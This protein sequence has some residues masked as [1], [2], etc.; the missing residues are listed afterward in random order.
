MFS[1]GVCAHI[2]RF[3]NFPLETLAEADEAYF[4]GMDFQGCRE[5]PFKEGAALAISG[6]SNMG[7]GMIDCKHAPKSSSRETKLRTM[8]SCAGTTVSAPIV[9]HKKVQLKAVKN[10][11]KRVI[12]KNRRLQYVRILP[13]FADFRNAKP[14]RSEV[15]QFLQ[16]RGS[17]DLFFN[18]FLYFNA[19]LIA[20]K[21]LHVDEDHPAAQRTENHE[22]HQ[23]H[24]NARERSEQM[25]TIGQILVNNHFVVMMVAKLSVP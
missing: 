23:Q 22:R 25:L 7:T 12:K 11:W 14:R 2:A 15:L 24:N 8:P 17:E 6:S 9:A 18:D 4:T 5:L 13:K 20:R 21:G 16:S 19:V 3:E 10:L 1:A